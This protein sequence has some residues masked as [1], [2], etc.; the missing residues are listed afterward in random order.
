M[1]YITT[2]IYY[3]NGTPHIGHLYTTVA[4]DVYARYWREQGEEVFF[5]T[6]TDEHGQ[7]VLDK[8]NE[9]GLDIHEYVDSLASSWRDFWNKSG[10]KYDKFIR[11]T[12]ANHEAYVAERLQELYDRGLIYQDS[13]FGWY[14]KKEER[15]WTDKDI[16][17]GLSPNDNPVERIEEKNY[18]FNL[19]AFREQIRQHILDNES[20]IQPDGRRNKVLRELEQPLEPL[21]ISR[22]KSRL[23]WGIE[24]PF[25]E[26][27]VTYVWFDA[28][29]NYISTVPEDYIQNAIHL[30]G[31][32]IL[33]FH[34]IYWPAMLLA[35][36]KP[37]PRQIFA[38]G[39]WL[40]VTERKVGKSE[41]NALDPDY[42]TEKFGKDG[43]R[44]LLLKATKFGVDG[45]FS[46]ERFVTEYNSD[47]SNN[48][49][50]LINRT[51]GMARKYYGSSTPYCK[52]L[53]GPDHSFV[54]NVLDLEGKYHG[55]LNRR[56]TNFELCEA[57][58]CITEIGNL[59][60]KYIHEIEPWAIEDAE[61][62]ETVIFNL[63]WC[64]HRIGLLLQP[65]TPDK[66]TEL[67]EAFANTGVLSEGQWFKPC[68]PLFPRIYED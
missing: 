42:L 47:L 9:L 25:D 18:F 60:N 31:K 14:D 58:E 21:C 8:A 33:I 29:L 20:F 63:L 17:N 44:Y 24:L 6:G 37:L 41:G 1:K 55:C 59:G 19:D 62:K 16:K 43:L 11:T 68:P 26:E 61:R 64:C 54:E 10:I 50:N 7:K 12:D 48:I 38:H 15:F 22:P 35:L 5:Q 34:T 67:L 49:G 53:D 56:E 27:Y 65:F 45:K 66:A 36:G 23:A 13:Y 52:K 3:I 2:P 57:L 32:D 39:W 40:D 30:I 51:F 4:A 28:L 46:E